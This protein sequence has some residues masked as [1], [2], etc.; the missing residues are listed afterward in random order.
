M[1][2]CDPDACSLDRFVMNRLPPE[3]RYFVEAHLS[4]CDNCRTLVFETQL[5]IAAYWRAAMSEAE[6]QWAVDAASAGVL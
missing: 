5:L 1:Y 2:F 6:S 3:Q 4:V